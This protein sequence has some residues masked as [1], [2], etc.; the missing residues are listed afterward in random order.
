MLKKRKKRESG[1]RRQSSFMLDSTI[2]IN[3]S[4]FLLY[5]KKRK[6][7]GIFDSCDIVN[8]HMKLIVEISY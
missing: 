6:K 3:K 2:K 8:C 1:V 7:R 4:P 5:V